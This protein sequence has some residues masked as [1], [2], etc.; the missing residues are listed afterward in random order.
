MFEKFIKCFR[1]F[2]KVA[3]MLI[4]PTLQSQRGGNGAPTKE[5]CVYS[6]YVTEW[7]SSRCLL[8]LEGKTK[9]ML[10]FMSGVNVV[11][12]FSEYGTRLVA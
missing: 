7:T 1:P 11:Y 3:M 4:W 5:E 8:G 6:R 12:L 9:A 10:R 2:K